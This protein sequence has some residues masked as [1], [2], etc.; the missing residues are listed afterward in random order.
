MNNHFAQLAGQRVLVTGASGFIGSALCRR[1]R[2]H[3]VELHAISRMV[4]TSDDLGIRWWQGDLAD[5]ATVERIV[6]E[7]RPDLVFHL[8]SHVAGA[9]EVEYVLPTM[10]SNLLSTINLMAAL[11][12]HDCDRLVLAGSMEEPRLDDANQT[13]SSPYA[14]AKWAASGYGRMFHLLYELP[15]VTLRIFMV[16]GPGQTDL[17]KLIPYVI[18]SLL[19]GETPQLTSGRRAVDWIFVEDVIDGLLAAATAADVGGASFDIGSGSSL[20]IRKIVE[21]LTNIIDPAIVPAFGAVE[22]RP[23]ETVRL[24]NIAETQQRLG[25]SPQTSPQLGLEKTVEW[26]RSIFAAHAEIDVASVHEA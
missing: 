4:Q 13:P 21:T 18:L 8:A 24:A 6:D 14:A 7:V 15:V 22:D 16:Y 3:D 20:T 2:N 12:S 11:A 26:Y 17:G 1:L 9:R 19:R 25:W 23:M 10:R 5:A